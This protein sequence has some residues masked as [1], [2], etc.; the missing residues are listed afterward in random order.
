MT[1]DQI[2]PLRIPRE[3][4]FAS[5]LT[6][7]LAASGCELLCGVLSRTLHVLPVLCWT[8]PIDN[9]RRGW[10]TFVALMFARCHLE[11]TIGKFWGK[12]KGLLLTG[13]GNYIVH[14]RQ[15]REVAGRETECVSLSLRFRYYWGRGWGPRVSQAHS[16]LVH[17]K[18][19]IGGIKEGK[20][21]KSGPNGQ[22]LES[23]KFSKTKVPQGGEAPGSLS[24]CQTLC[25]YR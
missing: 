2:W 12:N 4:W 11:I 8:Q 18:H 20:R 17:L 10:T 21:E 24:V 7:T 6:P 1:V 5:P 13:S 22:F 14:L 9:Q 19:K 23:T 16:L 15:H 25:Y 3:P